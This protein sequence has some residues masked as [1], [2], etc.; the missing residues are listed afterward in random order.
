MTVHRFLL[1]G[2]LSVACVGA[3]AG[4]GRA[5]GERDRRSSR[6]EHIHVIDFQ[7]VIEPVLAAYLGRR[8][9]EA[10]EA[11]ADCVV[12]RID[13]PG[14]RLD[15]ALDIGDRLMA[16]PDTVHVIAWVPHMA[17]SA[18]AMASIACDE[19]VMGPDA[20]L[21]DSQPVV[22]GAE[23]PQP[24]G[25]KIETVL[26]A[27]FRAYARQNGYPPA[28]AESMVSQHLE[29]LRVR[30]PRGRIW[31]VNGDDFRN[32]DEDGEFLS[33]IRWGELRQVGGPVVREGELLT[34]T[35]TEARDLQFLGRTFEEG[36][37]FPASEESLVQSLSAPGAKV[38]EHRMSLSEEAGRVLMQLAGV[39]SAI[40]VLALMLFLFQGPGLL[41]IIGLV[42][43]GLVLL[44]HA[45][46]EQVHGFP[47]FL[48]LLGVALLAI[49]V[50]VL[51]GFGIAGLLG[52]VTLGAGFLFLVEGVDL[53]SAGELPDDVLFKF[54]MQFIFTVLGG[55]GVMLLLS[56]VFPSFGPGKRL[57][58][59]TP[60]GVP[61]SADAEAVGSL[62]VGDLGEARSPLRPAGTALFDGNLVD[63]YTSGDFVEPGAP[64]RVVSVEGHR[65]E[66]R[67]AP[68][69]TDPA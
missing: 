68:T 54:G 19:I 48:I 53:G 47:L 13:S 63:V 59:A 18:A 4:L 58:L 40:V 9:D 12:L 27:K 8:L 26:R 61:V 43:L 41:T 28:L 50:F 36:G 55:I 49:E 7:G 15:S 62:A 17:Y 38:V 34:M 21:G 46:A 37:D 22:Q 69:R 56:R 29:V 5:E 24:I 51:P 31:F 10:V 60:T 64:V 11:G 3:W 14:G 20:H 2:L 6:F 16:V 23:G 42:C 52:I 45:T 67:P 57:V 1:A 30:D 44:I 39:L 35:A 65:V 66:V 32:A 25:E 33:G